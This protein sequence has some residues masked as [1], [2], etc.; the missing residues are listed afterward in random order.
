MFS[1]FQR[2]RPKVTIDADGN[3]SAAL[4]LAVGDEA[5]IGADGGHGPCRRAPRRPRSAKDLVV[6][7]DEFSDIGKYNGRSVE[8]ALR[9]E[10][11]KHSHIGYIFSGSEQ[12]VMLSMIQDSQRAFYKLGRI[13]ALGPI[14]RETY[15]KF[16]LNWL[17]KGGYAVDAKEVMRILTIGEDVPYNV[18]RLCNAMW[19]AAMESKTI[20]AT[21]I[22]KLPL[23]IV[24]QDSP[25][26]RCSGRQP[27]RPNGC[28]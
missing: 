21:L 11:Q 9:S 2:L 15:I 3:L 25:A 4:E 6:I 22:E 17:K 23:V 28:C 16:I 19:E 27:L 26:M 14:K 12:S 5:P 20:D 13:M 7:I 1:G 24:R 18:Q 8:K 10:I